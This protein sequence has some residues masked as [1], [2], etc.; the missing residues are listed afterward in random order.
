MKLN[1]MIE[2][3]R[4]DGGR[5]TFYVGATESI[6][7]AEWGIR[8]AVSEARAL[9]GTDLHVALIEPGTGVCKYR[10]RVRS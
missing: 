10:E 9:G 2:Y 3:T 5:G 4:A 1:P 7:E 8:H 6:T